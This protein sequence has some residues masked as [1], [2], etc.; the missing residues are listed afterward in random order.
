MRLISRGSLA[1][2]SVMKGQWVSFKMAPSIKLVEEEDRRDPCRS[3]STLIAQ[4]QEG[5]NKVSYLTFW[6]PNVYTTSGI[7]L[8]TYSN[9]LD[10]SI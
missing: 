1:R 4:Q 6:I 3:G 10:V 9:K 5:R 2:W 7:L 8:Y